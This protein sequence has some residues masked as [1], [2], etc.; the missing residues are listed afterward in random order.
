LYLFFQ[1]LIFTG[2]TK[3]LPRQD[4]T[5]AY[6]AFSHSQQQ[7]HAHSVIF[8]PGASEAFLPSPTPALLPGKNSGPGPGRAP[9]LCTVFGWKKALATIYSME[10]QPLVA[11][12]REPGLGRRKS[13]FLLGYSA[14]SAS[15][16]RPGADTRT[17]KSEKRQRARASRR[18]AAHACM[19]GSGRLGG[20]RR[21]RRCW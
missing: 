6:G 18:C 2:V 5:P 20:K 4:A 11:G 15:D 7:Q 3:T 10:Q 8:P 13:N 9:E 17:V 19:R 21:R 14:S 12:A 1:F 16:G